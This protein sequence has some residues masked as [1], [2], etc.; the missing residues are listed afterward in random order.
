MVGRCGSRT[1]REGE[2]SLDYANA[3]RDAAA[4][5][6]VALKTSWPTQISSNRTCQI[7]A[8]LIGALRFTDSAAASASTSEAT[9]SR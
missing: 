8:T 5:K 7:E 9:P 6:P 4:K 3:I 1:A 2:R